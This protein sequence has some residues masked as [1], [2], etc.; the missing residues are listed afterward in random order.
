MYSSSKGPWGER[1]SRSEAREA[2]QQRYEGAMHRM[3][4]PSESGT[5]AVMRERHSSSGAIESATTG[6]MR[7]RHMQQEPRGSGTAAVR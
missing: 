1:H 5:A 3:Q 2:Q 6:A 7:E 4:Q